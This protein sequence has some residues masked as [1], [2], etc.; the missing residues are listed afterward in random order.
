MAFFADFVEYF[1]VTPWK[2]LIV[3]ILSFVF[4][5]FISMKGW[6]IPSIQCVL[7]YYFV[8]VSRQKIRINNFTI[9][10]GLSPLTMFCYMATCY[11]IP[12]CALVFIEDFFA[13]TT[14]AVLEYI[15][16]AVLGYMLIKIVIFTEYY[17]VVSDI[18]ISKFERNYTYW[19]W[20]NGKC[21]EKA[22]EETFNDHSEMKYFLYPF[23]H[24][25]KIVESR[26]ENH[27]ISLLESIR[28]RGVQFVSAKYLIEKVNISIIEITL[29][30]K[31]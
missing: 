12:C 26:M 1:R 27:N 30:K 8:W 22:I 3:D 19:K 10:R 23:R 7:A 29:P 9:S 15:P 11:F 2:I 20:D 31:Y 18:I 4:I 13:L 28:Y 16:I 5:I 14:I 25:I 6:L 17:E 21:L 24:S